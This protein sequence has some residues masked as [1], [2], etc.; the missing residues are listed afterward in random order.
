MIYAVSRFSKLVASP[1]LRANFVQST[2]RFLREHKF[3]GLDLDW[4]YPGYRDGSSHDDKDRY[5]TLIKVSAHRGPQLESRRAAS[6]PARFALWFHLLARPAARQQSMHR[7]NVC[8]F[9]RTR[10]QSLRR[11]R[12]LLVAIV[13]VESSQSALAGY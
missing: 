4:E 9:T 6:S 1:E 7:I 12:P 10:P 8:P 11:K 5:A 13:A 3:D 2:I